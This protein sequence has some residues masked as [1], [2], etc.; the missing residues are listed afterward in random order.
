MDAIQ[1]AFSHKERNSDAMRSF[2]FRLR[3]QFSVNKAYR[4]PKELEW[5]QSLR[6]YKGLYDP[7]VKIEENNS[8]VY[9]K[10]TRSKVNIVLSRLHEMLFPETDKNWEIEPTPEPK[11]AKETVRQ[12]ALSLVQADPQ[13]GTVIKMPTPQDL[14]LAIKKHAKDTCE[15][16]SSEIDDQLTEMDYPEETKKVLRS[17]LM[18]G[19]GV[20]KGPMIAKRTKRRWKPTKAGDDYEEQVDDEEV[21]DMQ[22]TRL[23]DW[24]PDMSVTEMEHIT[25]SFER[26][27]MNKHDLRM[28]AKRSGF[29]S[30]MISQYLNDHPDG[31][32]VPLNWEVDLQVIEVEAGSNKAGVAQVATGETDLDS[33]STNRQLGKR[34]EVLEFWGYVD[35]HDLEACGWAVP[36]VELEY[37]ANVWLLGNVPIASFLYPGALD[38]YKVF[39]YEK[40]ETSIFGEGLARVMRH[41]QIAIAAAARM[42]LDNAA[43][44][45]G[46]QVEVNWSLMTPDTDFQSFYSRKLWFR[47]GKGIDAQYPALRIYNI[48]SHVAELLQIVEAFKAFADEETTLPTW[49]IGQM[50]SNETAQAASGRQSTITISIK[51]V[52]KNFDAYTEKVIKDI[53]AWNMDF[54]PRT[55]IKGD[56]KCKAR[57]VSSLVMKEIRMQALAQ[58]STTLT[59]EERD[60]IPTRDFLAEKF[61]AHDLRTRLLTEDE[62]QKLRDA[63]QQSE[64][65]KLSLEMQRAEIAY[66]KSQTMGQLTKA[67]GH[68][69]EANVAAGAAP[70]GQEVTDPRLTEAEIALENTKVQGE[71]EKIRREK[72][73][74]DLEMAQKTEAHNLEMA[75]KQSQTAHDIANKDKMTAVK[76]ESAKEMTKAGVQAKKTAAKMKPAAKKPA[77]TAK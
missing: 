25:G 7:E 44:V 13:S 31:D 35:G 45:A 60:Y 23:W 53:Y 12:I 62:V 29:Y 6:Q 43:C 67:K 33:R 64:A 58:L 41:S 15:A 37:A 74:H 39:Y 48:D 51:D 24:Y 20:M 61:K 70:E 76:V 42:V 47:E 72:E 22:F 5:L 38:Q 32:Y 28:L 77:K 2:G 26:H 30:E 11:I 46:P 8:K 3:N 57:G 65:V 63:R 59:P 4:R 73:S 75:A 36:D 50:V 34:Y 14:L 18:Y 66:K 56:Y 55:D 69:V 40:D 52:V 27:V 17:G 16:M 10:I 71:A 49:L 68:N 21:P 54:N 9:P 19:T 1:Q